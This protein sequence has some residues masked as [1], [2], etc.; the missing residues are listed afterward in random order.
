[1][2]YI[3]GQNIAGS[4]TKTYDVIA[5]DVLNFATYAQNINGVEYISGSVQYN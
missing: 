2:A 3:T 5:G 4:P 1:V